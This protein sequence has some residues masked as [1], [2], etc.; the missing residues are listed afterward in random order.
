MAS[1]VGRVERSRVRGIPLKSSDR[2][3]IRASGGIGRSVGDRLGHVAGTAPP[4]R[5][6]SNPTGR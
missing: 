2:R 1:G 4:T 3:F 6:I 5:N